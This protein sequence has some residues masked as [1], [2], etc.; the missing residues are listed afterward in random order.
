LTQST[1]KLPEIP[2]ELSALLRDIVRDFPAIMND[3]LVGIYLWGSLTYDAFDE[4]CSDV[5]SVVVTR[6][7]LDDAEFSAL[8]RWFR[9]AAA[10]N[11]WTERLEMRFVI[12]G[13]FLDKRSRCCGFYSGKFTR[14]GS[15][16]NPIIWLNVG[17][18]GVTLWGRDARLIAPVVTDQC[19]NDALLLELNYLMEGLEKNTQ[20]RSD[21]A[22]RYN[23]YAVLTACRILHT[24]QHRAIIAKE[25]A[26]EWAMSSFPTEWRAVIATA[27][28]NRTRNRGATTP[29]MEVDAASF[30]RF[31]REQVSRTLSKR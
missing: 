23:A 10:R 30:V 15:D 5:D 20:D 6:R 14:H 26:C 13:E 18:C 28:E 24:A 1:P 22:F 19:L 11:P 4:R 3:N 12:D 29:Y 21:R 8:E 31:A 7:D 9:E 16:G 17:E 27:R 2:D 25:Q